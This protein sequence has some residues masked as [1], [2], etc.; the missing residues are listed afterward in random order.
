LLVVCESVVRP[1]R[2]GASPH[3]W[4][5]SVTGGC[6]GCALC[7]ARPLMVVTGVEGTF[8]G[9]DVA[10]FAWAGRPLPPPLDM[11]GTRRE[12][13]DGCFRLPACLTGPGESGATLHVADGTRQGKWHVQWVPA[14][15]GRTGVMPQPA[16]LL[17]ASSAQAT[18]AAR[19]AFISTD[20]FPKNTKQTPEFN[21]RRR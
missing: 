19:D 13:P 1:S 3:H 5:G 9:R 20:E 15:A 14:L 4:S 12:A 16:R 7:V 10:W 17:Y 21:S 11:G 2:G 6:E 8:S 18:S